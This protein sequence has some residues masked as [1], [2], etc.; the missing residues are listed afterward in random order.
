VRNH[1]TAG[2]MPGCD[3]CLVVLLESSA[4][5]KERAVLIPVV[6]DFVTFW[7]TW[8]AMPRSTHTMAR[9]PIVRRGAGVE[10]SR[11]AAH[12]EEH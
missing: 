9:R 2:G 4:R 1:A 7:N 3:R 10:D 12:C 5:S 6:R 11:C 8:A